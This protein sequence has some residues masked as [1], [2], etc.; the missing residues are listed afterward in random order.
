MVYGSV[1]GVINPVAYCLCLCLEKQKF[2][3]LFNNLITI[4]SKIHQLNFLQSSFHIHNSSFWILIFGIFLN[5][6]LVRVP[7]TGTNATQFPRRGLCLHEPQ[8]SNPMGTANN[9]APDRGLC[10]L[11]SLFCYHNAAPYGRFYP[12]AF[13]VRNRDASFVGITSAF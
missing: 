13:G 2:Y 9:A 10:A 7:R 5:P 12:S 6:A 3:L 8:H 11:R 4:F 1:L